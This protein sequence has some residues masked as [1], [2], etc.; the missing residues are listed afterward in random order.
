MFFYCDLTALAVNSVVSL[1]MDHIWKPPFLL[2]AAKNVHNIK[3]T[4][5]KHRRQ[6]LARVAIILWGAPHACKP[7][8][9]TKQS[10][11]LIV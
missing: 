11:P 6:R 1:S 2:C 7:L 8:L 5:L 3:S 10:N 4:V 9:A